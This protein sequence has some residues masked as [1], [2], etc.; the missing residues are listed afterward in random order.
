LGHGIGKRPI[1]K[2]LAVPACL[3]TAGILS[4]GFLFVFLSRHTSIAYRYI[5]ELY[6]SALALCCGALFMMHAGDVSP[7]KAAD[8][9]GR[10]FGNWYTAACV[11]LLV[12]FLIGVGVRPYPKYA[13]AAPRD[14]FSHATVRLA[15]DAERTNS[16]KLS[17]DI[18]VRYD[19]PTPRVP[20]E[21]LD[22]KHL[23]FSLLGW[24]Q[25][26][27]CKVTRLVLQAFLP[28][29]E[30][31][32]ITLIDSDNVGNLQN[33]SEPIRAKAGNDHLVRTSKA[34]RGTDLRVTFCRD[35]PLTETRV[36]LVTFAWAPLDAKG[37][38]H[39]DAIY[40]RS[41]ESDLAPGAVSSHGA[42]PAKS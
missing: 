5:V 29:K 1:M 7:K 32:S 24:R 30:C 22:I 3:S 19:C 28:F 6:P 31:L 26:D 34:W 20:P 21:T 15:V 36:E 11:F 39:H 8:Q 9:A 14:Y 27:S 42:R 10:R 35:S 12:I 33:V 17:E 41:I 40:L 38:A 25:S 13:N 37:H 23:G 2:D 4:F 18:P 16:Q